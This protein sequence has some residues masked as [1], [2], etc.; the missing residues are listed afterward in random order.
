MADVNDY[1][2]S[3]GMSGFQAVRRAAADMSEHYKVFYCDH[4]NNPVFSSVI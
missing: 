3:F 4:S 1:V 2:R